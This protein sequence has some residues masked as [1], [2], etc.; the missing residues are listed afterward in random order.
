MKL[1]SL[2][3]C[4]ALAF[5]QSLTPVNPAPA[6]PG[7][8]YA[9]TLNLAGVPS[10]GM[11]AIQFTVSVPT[12]WAFTSV[13]TAVSNKEVDCNTASPRLCV[14][15]GRN[16]TSFANGAVASIVLTPPATAATGTVTI[17]IAAVLG[18]D[19]AG[20]P[21]TMSGAALTAQVVS[22]DLNGD[23]MINGADLAE[24]LSQVL[25]TKPCTTADLNKDSACKATD[26]ILEIGGWI[27]AGSNP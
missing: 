5:A 3:F 21:I 2:L 23:G 1:F 26:L 15:F 13:S 12:G 17:S 11:A 27:M 10:G 20:I 25:G 7:Q 6:I 24:S 8:P 14:L 19:P 4:S 22:Y 18:S 9:V 16:L